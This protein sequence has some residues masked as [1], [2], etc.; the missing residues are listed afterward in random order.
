[1][2]SSARRLLRDPVT[3]AS[4]MSCAGY[5]V[6]ARICLIFP[7]STFS[8]FA[9]GNARGQDE[10][11]GCHLLAVTADGRAGDVTELE[12]WDCPPWQAP[13]RASIDS[14][15]CPYY[16]NVEDKIRDH[17]ASHAG[18]DPAAEPVA[19]VRRVWTFSRQGTRTHDHV[20]AACRAV[21]R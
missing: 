1:M 19:L 9:G 8:M 7:F 16:L 12:S 2:S 6:I 10:V 13:A 14:L 15:H 17:I 18:H 21:R 3:L 11:R 4:V 20:I 5:F